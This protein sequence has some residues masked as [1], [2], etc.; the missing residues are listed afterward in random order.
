MHLIKI[1]WDIYE[2]VLLNDKTL[3]EQEH[4]MILKCVDMPLSGEPRER[5]YYKP[6]ICG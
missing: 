4:P 3:E 2:N 1:F 6:H 5:Q